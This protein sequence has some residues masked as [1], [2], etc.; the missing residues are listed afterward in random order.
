MK[1]RLMQ[2]VKGNYIGIFKYGI[3][4][5]FFGNNLKPD[6]SAYIVDKAYQQINIQ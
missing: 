1:V 2:V 6:V 4:H 3:I 5:H